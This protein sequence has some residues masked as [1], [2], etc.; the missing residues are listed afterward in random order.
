MRNYLIPLMLF[1]LLMAPLRVLPESPPSIQIKNLRH[2]G[3][4]CPEGSI[5]MRTI[6]HGYWIEVGL[7]F[8]AMSISADG[9][10]D[11]AQAMSRNC[12]VSLAFQA[13]I[14]HFVQLEAVKYAGIATMPPRASGDLRV[15]GWSAGAPEVK[16]A[17]RSFTDKNH[18]PGKIVFHQ[19]LKNLGK[20]KCG[21]QAEMFLDISAKLDLPR[22]P[23]SHALIGLAS[24]LGLRIDVLQGAQIIARAKIFKCE[25]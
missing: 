4:G 16:A 12:Q 14:G 1:S 20:G 15:A 10:S 2:E 18:K 3:N 13:P 17:Q 24:E 8:K 9:K 19:E 23:G 7:F 5:E 21:E 6:D 22:Q 11:Q 25:E